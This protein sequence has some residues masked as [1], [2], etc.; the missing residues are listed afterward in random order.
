MRRREAAE[1]TSLGCLWW[2]TVLLRRADDRRGVERGGDTIRGALDDT[3]KRRRRR[4]VLARAQIEADRRRDRRRRGRRCERDLYR[5]VEVVERRDAAHARE[6]RW[7]AAC[8]HV[9]RTRER[10]DPARVVETE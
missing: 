3:H 8:R 9:A 4:R 2:R 6:T 10:D 5:V 7:C 1:Q